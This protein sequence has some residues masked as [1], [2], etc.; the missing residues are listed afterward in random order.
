MDVIE[1]GGFEDT[2]KSASSRFDNNAFGPRRVLTS[3]E[4]TLFGPRLFDLGKD[5]MIR[6]GESE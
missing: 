3:G 6:I 2:K 1:V 4:L 5:R